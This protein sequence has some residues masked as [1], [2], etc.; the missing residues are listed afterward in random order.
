MKC[1]KCGYNSFESHDTCVK[2][3][4]DLTGFKATYGVKSIVLPPELR[5]GMAEELL[6]KTALNA[7]VADAG[8]APAD[9]FS[10][11]LPEVAAA[12]AVDDDPFNFDDDPAP[13]PSMAPASGG[14]SF[15]DSASTAQ[16]KA[17]EDAFADLLESNTQKESSDFSWDDTPEPAPAAAAKP[18]GD[19][20]DSLFGDQ[21]KPKG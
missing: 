19:D 10:F 11:D 6:A 13:A 16:D 5:A 21:D 17:E 3:S 14:F 4:N 20:F 1:P 8:E 12:P 9:M 15:G 7:P 18:A 2:C